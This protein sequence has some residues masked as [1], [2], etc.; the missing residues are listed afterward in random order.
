VKGPL[1]VFGYDYLRDHLGKERTEAIRLLNYEGLWGHEYAYE[2]LNFV[3]GVRNV[4]D[5]RNALAAEFGPIQIE[6]VEEYL[7]ALESI[8]VIQKA[9]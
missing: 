3:D 1:S 4:T 6:L 2:A 9:K 8:Q 7:S 5:I